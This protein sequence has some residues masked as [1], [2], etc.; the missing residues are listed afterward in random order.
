M[1]KINILTDQFR[2]EVLSLIHNSDGDPRQIISS[3]VDEAVKEKTIDIDDKKIFSSDLCHML[4]RD[5]MG[6]GPIQRYIDDPGV[7]EI[8]V[9]SPTDIYVEKRGIL[10]RTDLYFA[11][12]DHIIELIDRILSLTGKE[13]SEDSPFI[14]ARLSDGSRVNCVLP[15]MSPTGPKITIRKFNHS[16]LGTDD[17]ISYGT[18]TE[19][20]AVFLKAAIESRLNIIVSGNTSSGKTTLLNALSA[21]IPDRERIITIEDACELRLPKPHVVPLETRPPGVSEKEVS[22]RDHVRNALRMRPDRLLIGEVRGAETFDMLQ[23][24]NT[25][26]NGSLCTIHANSP[27]QVLS[28]L[29]TLTLLAGINTPYTSVREQISSAFDLIVHMARF[30]DGSRKIT[31]ITEIHGMQGDIITTHDLFLYIHEP[32]D[33]TESDGSPVGYFKG[34]RAP[35]IYKSRMELYGIDLPLEIYN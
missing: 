16:L 13:I 20:M 3:A 23:A 33:K 24:M 26:H 29:E 27:R 34:T 28:R 35:S 9:N 11:S 15:S 12:D 17:L 4:L 21:Y 5:Y 31:H 6:Y 14:D 32:K 18:L 10:A 7:S 30:N 25:G 22:L 8:M 1:F 2:S 19:N